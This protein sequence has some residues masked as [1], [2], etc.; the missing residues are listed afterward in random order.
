MLNE[1][2][3]AEAIA[4]F[5]RTSNSDPLSVLAISDLGAAL[6]ASGQREKAE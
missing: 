4:Y 5:E 1:G 3:V 2:K 6:C